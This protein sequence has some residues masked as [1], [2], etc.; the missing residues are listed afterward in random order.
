M[1]VAFNR[2]RNFI[3]REGMTLFFLRKIALFKSSFFGSV[4]AGLYFTAWL[5]RF[6]R[7]KLGRYVFKAQLF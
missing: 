1:A 6:P 4:V 5:K 3:T 7:K 2:E